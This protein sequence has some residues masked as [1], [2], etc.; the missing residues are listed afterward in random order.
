M[1][2]T[3]LEFSGDVFQKRLETVRV[4]QDEVGETCLALHDPENGGV[5]YP[6]PGNQKVGGKKGEKETQK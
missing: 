2:T 3:S 5:N 4:V 1:P 6:S